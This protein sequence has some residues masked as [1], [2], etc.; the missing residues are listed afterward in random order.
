MCT[1]ETM[2]CDHKSMQR[3]PL[4]SVEEDECHRRWGLA[5]WF[6]T[7]SSLPS[8]CQQV[9][10]A[11][12]QFD[13]LSSKSTF[14]LA[15]Q[16]RALFYISMPGQECGCH[17]KPKNVREVSLAVHSVLI[18][19]YYRYLIWCLG[20]QTQS[21]EVETGKMYFLLNLNDKP[22]PFLV[23]ISTMVKKKKKKQQ[24]FHTAIK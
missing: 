22:A 10:S 8:R 5:T 12:K 11:R 4:P 19:K 3:F 2:G 6:M 13:V 1:S 20:Q 24:L 16:S 17:R 14:V 18:W 15:L 7:L 21:K 23:E 9:D